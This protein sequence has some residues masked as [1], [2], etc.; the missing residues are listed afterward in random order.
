MFQQ[1]FRA[2]LGYSFLKMISCQTILL[3]DS[4]T[5][6]QH[7]LTITALHSGLILLHTVRKETPHR[8]YHWKLSFT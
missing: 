1:H 8:C 4:T 6:P 7:R 3:I 5:P 2:V